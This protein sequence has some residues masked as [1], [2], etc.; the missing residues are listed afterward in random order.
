MTL[1]WLRAGAQIVLIGG[2]V[3]FLVKTA[4]EHAGTFSAWDGTV[5]WPTLLAAS[6]L[7]LGAFTLMVLTWSASLRWWNAGVSLLAALRIW[8][9]SNLARF[10]PGAVWQF[11]GLAA[12]AADEGISPLAATGA[13]LLQQ[14]ILLAT[15]VV[16]AVMMAP[17]WVE[18]IAGGLPPAA[19]A[20]IAIIALA[21]LA[22]SIPLM[23]PAIG[24]G[25][26]RMVKRQFAWPRPA[27]GAFAGYTVA[28]VIPW[29]IYAAA[30]WMFARA[31]IGESAPSLLVAGGAFVASYVA[32]IVAVF[33][34]A[35]IAVREA[36]LVAM[37]T[38]VLDGRVALALALGSRLWMIAL[39]ILMA[40]VVVGLYR[41]RGRPARRAV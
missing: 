20:I 8:S 13:V 23:M 1:R 7:V 21:I 41:A 2:A 26:G 11:A 36:A 3:L 34:P 18:P 15:G 6:M 9:L 22:V 30:F 32:G 24:R 5:D 38:P 27:P 37:L 12:L 40:A 35:G 29:L 17:A 19:T 14:L 25:L 16:V 28:L 10:I 31:L 39:E 4:R 33:A